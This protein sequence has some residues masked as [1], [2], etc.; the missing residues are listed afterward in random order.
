MPEVVRNILI[1]YVIGFIC[2][3]GIMM[4]LM[5]GNLSREDEEEFAYC[6]YG[7]C[8]YEYARIVF[9]ILRAV[10]S[11]FIAVLWPF[12]P[13]FVAGIYIYDWINNNCPELMGHMADD[14]EYVNGG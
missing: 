8:D 3:F 10:V 9:G 7:Y 4:F 11:I 14:R 12:I 6:E 5:R 2:A 13:V 1:I